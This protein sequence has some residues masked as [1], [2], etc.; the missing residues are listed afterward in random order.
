MKKLFV[1]FS[2]FC[3]LKISAQQNFDWLKIKQYKI[4][5]LSD[6]LKETSGLTFFEDKLY[7]FNDGGNT[8]EIFEINPKNGKIHN[9]IN[10]NVPNFDWEAITNDSVNLYIGDF[11]NNWGTRKDLK[12]YQFNPNSTEIKEIKFYYPEQKEFVKKPQ[13]NN[14]DAESMIFAHQNIH[15]FTKEWSSYQTTHYLINPYISEIQ[16]AK[17][18]ETYNLGYVATDAYYFDKKL[19]LIG[20]TKKMEVFLTV[21][22]ESSEGFFFTEKPKKYYLGLASNLGQIEGIAVDNEGIYISGEDFNFKIF[23]AK[24][25]FYFIPKEKMK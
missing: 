2:F 15:L 24:P 21:F 4:A 13:N 7:T 20:Y 18:V 12:I 3:V 9:K 23:K 1:L 11:G 8:S 6:S 16:P 10:L 17:K 25:S 14:W 5:T 22:Q 19:Y